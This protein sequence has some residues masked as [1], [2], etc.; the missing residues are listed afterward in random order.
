[1]PKGRRFIPDGCDALEARVAAAHGLAAHVAHAAAVSHRAAP[2]KAAIHPIRAPRAVAPGPAAPKVE[3]NEQYA[4]FSVAF[5]Q[6]VGTFFAS[7]PPGTAASSG[8]LDGYIITSTDLLSQQLVSYFN[9]LPYK[10][11]ANTPGT[12]SIYG[13]RAAIQTFVQQQI[14]GTSTN[15]DQFTG[16]PNNL[17]TNLLNVPLPAAIN[18]SGADLYIESADQVIEASRLQTLD[19]VQALFKNGAPV[20]YNTSPTSTSPGSLTGSSPSGTGTG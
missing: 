6:A 2:H 1:M 14:T 8:T 16:A 18:P 15:P 7:I 10:L 5:T 11:P 17:Q 12:T 20:N 9:G 3:I 19:G 13:S 4:A